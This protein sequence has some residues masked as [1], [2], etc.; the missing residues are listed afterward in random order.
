MNVEKMS[1][2]FLLE[3]GFDISFKYVSITK[4][5]RKIVD[6]IV[7]QVYNNKTHKSILFDSSKEAVEE[8]YAILRN[9]NE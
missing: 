5:Y 3:K 1:A 9:A 2:Q 4:F 7:Y 8:L 6:K